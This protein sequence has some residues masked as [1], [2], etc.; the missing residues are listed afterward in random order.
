ME[1]TAGTAD[2]AQQLEGCQGSSS[3]P[4]GAAILV[5]SG[6]YEEGTGELKVLTYTVLAIISAATGLFVWVFGSEA[7]NSIKCRGG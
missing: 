5:K 4:G 1:S 3:V 2:Q 6:F 7:T